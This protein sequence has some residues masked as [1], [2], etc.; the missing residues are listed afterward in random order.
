MKFIFGLDEDSNII[1]TFVCSFI[2]RG[3][4]KKRIRV[5]TSW[6]TVA[7]LFDLYTVAGVRDFAFCGVF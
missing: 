7:F 3:G 6:R 4:R 5:I 2:A 1:R